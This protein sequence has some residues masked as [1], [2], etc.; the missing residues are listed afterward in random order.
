[1]KTINIFGFGQMGQQVSALFLLLGYKVVVHSTRQIN[2][3]LIN[4]SAR[5]LGRRL[6]LKEEICGQVVHSENG[7]IFDAPSIDT[8]IE[9]LAV[10]QSIYS[11]F[12]NYSDELF[13]SN[14]SS[15]SPKEIGADVVGLHFLIQ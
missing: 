10:K 15:F 3:Q 2:S 13:A 7:K 11:K 4:K 9:D 1:M 12:R 6:D 5:L 14:T 8:T